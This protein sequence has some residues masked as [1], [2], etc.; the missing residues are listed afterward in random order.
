MTERMPVRL[1]RT[2]ARLNRWSAS[3]TS[4]PRRTRA[5]RRWG[6]IGRTSSIERIRTR[7]IGAQ[8]RATDG[9]GGSQ[10]PLRAARP[11]S[12]CHTL[13]LRAQWHGQSADTALTMRES[14]PIEILLV[15]DNAGDARLARE[16][17]RDA[18]VR[19]NLTW[20]SDGEE[21]LAFLR[22]E[23]KYSHAPR[24]DLILLDLNLPRKDGREV[25]TEITAA[26]K[27]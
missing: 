8:Q 14:K 19:N 12:H 1:S 3:A 16:A 2:P 4:A 11:L 5:R 15:E 17:L 26:D 23:G 20:L 6:R 21:A 18:K 24:P 22:R 9:R 7:T 27:F 13:R 10:N 25:L